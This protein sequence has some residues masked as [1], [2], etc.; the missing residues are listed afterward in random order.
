MIVTYLLGQHYGDGWRCLWLPRGKDCYGV[1]DQVCDV[2]VSYIQF[3]ITT[4][5]SIAGREGR[6][7]EGGREGGRE[8]RGGREGGREGGR[9]DHWASIW[10]R[11]CFHTI[12]L[13][14]FGQTICSQN[15]TH[16]ISMSPKLMTQTL[17]PTTAV[18][19]RI[20]SEAVT[21]NVPSASQNGSCGAGPGLYLYMY[22]L[23]GMQYGSCGAP[24]GL[25]VPFVSQYGSCG[26]PLD[27]PEP[28]SPQ[29][30]PIILF[31]ISLISSLLF[32][33]I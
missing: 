18:S 16:D 26:A 19:P 3:Y 12:P 20:W 32:P 1:L 14:Q 17:R 8:E 23:L 31:R 2:L 7:G 22:L 6:R 28:I 11:Y 9:T 24:L 33:H 25:Q 30:L 10:E 4:V 13:E 15:K 27:R 5:V 29:I 21:H